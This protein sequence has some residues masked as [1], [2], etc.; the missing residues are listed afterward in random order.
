MSDYTTLVPP[1]SPFKNS[2]ISREMLS[3]AEPQMIS[4]SSTEKILSTPI[5]NI[6][7]NA[8][9]RS[10]KDVLMSP[11]SVER[12]TFSPI[13]NLLMMSEGNRKME[14]TGRSF[15]P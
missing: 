9:I 6:A 4:Q 7:I 5:V 15:L 8:D 11:K 12:D 3:A 1:S 13:S 2:V 10:L 14:A